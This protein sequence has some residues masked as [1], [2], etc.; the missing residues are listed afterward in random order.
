MSVTKNR[1]WVRGVQLGEIELRVEL[2]TAVPA[3]PVG[4]YNIDE[5]IFNGN[6]IGFGYLYIFTA[7]ADRDHVLI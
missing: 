4:K 7:G 1:L 3:D 6:P 2:F 5:M